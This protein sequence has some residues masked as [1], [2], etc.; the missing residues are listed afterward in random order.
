MGGPMRADKGAGG[1]RGTGRRCLRR[2]RPLHLGRVR[3]LG[4]AVAALILFL[5]KAS[6]SGCPLRYVHTK[7]LIC[8]M[9]YPGWCVAVC[10]LLGFA[11]SMWLQ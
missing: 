9:D 11:A 10:G 5:R 7:T 6:A 2:S 1:D 4:A 8:F 3:R